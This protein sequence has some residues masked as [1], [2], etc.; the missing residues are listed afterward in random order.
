MSLTPTQPRTHRI[1]PGGAR[2]I[3]QVDVHRQLQPRIHSMAHAGGQALAEGACCCPVIAAEALIP[4]RGAV[5]LRMVGIAWRQRVSIWALAVHVVR[6]AA[7]PLVA[8]SPR[9]P[10]PTAAP[11]R[12]HH[13]YSQVRP[14]LVASLQFP[15]SP[16]D[17]LIHNHVLVIVHIIGSDH[18]IGGAPL[19]RLDLRSHNVQWV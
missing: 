7:A 4:G 18:K 6:A 1:A 8:L 11:L 2:C 13:T 17:Q 3:I 15:H 19:Q 9:A 16:T 10:C 14:A 5:A 12:E